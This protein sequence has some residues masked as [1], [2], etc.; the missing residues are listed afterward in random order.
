[1]A[2]AER[3]ARLAFLKRPSIASVSGGICPNRA[4]DCAE[5]LMA[6][7]SPKKLRVKRALIF[8][9]QLQ[10]AARPPF[11]MLIWHRTLFMRN[12]ERAFGGRSASN[13]NEASKYSF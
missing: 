3:P 9:V 5:M 10:R 8:M 1:M 2:Y 13:N 6:T 12:R 4:S 11:G 7:K